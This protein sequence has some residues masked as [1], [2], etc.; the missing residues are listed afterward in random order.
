LPP[1]ASRNS[2]S[3]MFTSTFRFL[4]TALLTEP[5]EPT[6]PVGGRWSRWSCR[7]RASTVGMVPAQT[8]RGNQNHHH[9]VVPTR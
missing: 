6:T 8:A 2:L 4:S 1:M 5:K 3:V 7:T 9:P